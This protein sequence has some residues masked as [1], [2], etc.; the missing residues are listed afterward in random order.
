MLVQLGA[1]AEPQVRIFED[2]EEE[3]KEAEIVEIVREICEF[4]DAALNTSP[5]QYTLYSIAQL[6]THYLQRHN[7]PDQ[8]EAVRV[9]MSRF[10]V[11]IQNSLRHR[12]C[13]SNHDVVK[14]KARA[15]SCTHR[16]RRDRGP[17]GDR[18]QTG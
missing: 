4:L 12:G 7:Y 2:A 8:P 11:A 16:H 6:A 1:H 15:A 14:E 18:C 9:F 17:R 13:S 3:V 10:A 5:H